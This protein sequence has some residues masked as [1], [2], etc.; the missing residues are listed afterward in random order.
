MNRATKD[1]TKFLIKSTICGLALFGLGG[2]GVAAYFFDVL[3]FVPFVNLVFVLSV[4]ALVVLMFTIRAWQE[5]QASFGYL[6]VNSCSEARLDLKD[7]A[8]RDTVLRLIEKAPRVQ[9][10]LQAIQ[11]SGRQFNAALI[12]PLIRELAFF[13]NDPEQQA[14][15]FE[16]KKQV[17]LEFCD[18]IVGIGGFL[19]DTAHLRPI[20]QAF[21]ALS[22]G[23][24]GTSSVGRGRKTK[25][26]PSCF[27][28]CRDSKARTA[29]CFASLPQCCATHHYFFISMRP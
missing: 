26:Q 8:L 20:F 6:C 28:H 29:G 23:Q 17:L 15:I 21:L 13:L 2:Y 12:T 18:N 10:G 3:S 11:Q 19:W 16:M 5:W 4:V 1:R 7:R 14:H 25:V 27:D 22:Q 24:R 9:D